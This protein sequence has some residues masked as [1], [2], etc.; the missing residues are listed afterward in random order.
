MIYSNMNYSI[1]WKQVYRNWINPLDERVEFALQYSN[2]REA[3]KIIE[4]IKNL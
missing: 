1:K 4:R 2:F 3:N